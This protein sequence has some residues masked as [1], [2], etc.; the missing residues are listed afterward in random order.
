MRD[1]MLMKTMSLNATLTPA[2]HGTKPS[3]SQSGDV[4]GARFSRFQS[5]KRLIQGQLTPHAINF[6]N[7]SHVA[8]EGAGPLAP[9]LDN[10]NL[11]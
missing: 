6:L 2:I 9:G 11:P 1:G 4:D 7:A 8:K 3:E 10:P 5:Q